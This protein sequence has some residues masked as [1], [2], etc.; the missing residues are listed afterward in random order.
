MSKPRMRW[1]TA[2]NPSLMCE[3]I[4]DSIH[5]GLIM[6]SSLSATG[7]PSHICRYRS[8]SRAL[9]CSISSRST[10]GKLGLLLKLALITIAFDGGW[11]IKRW[12]VSSRMFFGL[13][14]TQISL[15][16]V[17]IVGI[18]VSHISFVMLSASSIQ[19]IPA[20]S[21]DL[22]LAGSFLIP[23]KMKF[24]PVPLWTMVDFNTSN[25]SS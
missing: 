13:N 15:P 21:S 2:S 8:P 23:K 9:H 12:Y 7:S 16:S 6:A 25:S 14:D 11:T 1:P 10:S 4:A 22:I 5:F 3:S 20:P 24:V 18:N 17:R 19:Q